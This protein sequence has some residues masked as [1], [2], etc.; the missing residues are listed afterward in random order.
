MTL[1]ELEMADSP[2]P[3]K[4]RHETSRRMINEKAYFMLGL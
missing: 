1:E 4:K 3:E 2:C